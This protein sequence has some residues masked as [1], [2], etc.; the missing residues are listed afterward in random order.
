MI[1][2]FLNGI[3]GRRGLV[4]RLFSVNTR[5]SLVR[6]FILSLVL[7]L[8]LFSAEQ[9]ANS[10]QE[11]QVDDSQ[12]WMRDFFININPLTLMFLPIDKKETLIYEEMFSAWDESNLQDFDRGR[13]TKGITI[14][15]QDGLY[16]LS[17]ERFKHF[18]K[19]YSKYHDLII[20]PAAKISSRN[21][22]YLYRKLKTGDEW[23]HFKLKNGDVIES[24]VWETIPANSTTDGWLQIPQPVP[25]ENAPFYSLVKKN[26][27][28]KT[29]WEK[30]YLLFD[31]WWGFRKIGRD[32][33]FDDA[34]VNLYG[35]AFY[36]F[37]PGNLAVID[38]NR[39]FLYFQ[40]SRKIF[41]L[42][43]NGQP[44]T[45]DQD[46]LVVSLNDY[47][48][49]VRDNKQYIGE[50]SGTCIPEN[51]INEHSHP[52]IVYYDGM[53]ESIA[54]KL[55]LPVYSIQIKEKVNKYADMTPC[56][57]KYGRFNEK[58]F[59]NIVELNK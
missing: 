49:L 8:S 52:D 26:A 15:N 46:L 27:K 13:H 17:G 29:I 23:T 37:K 48:K 4:M 11:K 7:F 54:K 41:R 19:V 28:G 51:I 50:K 33:S 35:A 25:G 5:I 59:D 58:E 12:V 31:P 57:Q 2:N 10:K 16:F 42:D 24:N 43:I 56:I 32:T 38:E 6:I 21:P 39:I 3:N 18:D 30:V 47:K 34:F 55:G 40:G 14:Q 22:A 36:Y 53:G 9:Q 20:D 45:K 1:V 44:K